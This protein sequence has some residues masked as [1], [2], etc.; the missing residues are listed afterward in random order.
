MLK[1]QII[2]WGWLKGVYIATIIIAGGF[3][4][5]IIFMPTIAMTLLGVSC[6]PA[7][8][9]TLG[10]VFLAFGLLSILGLRDPLKYV[11]ILLLQLVYKTIWLLGVVLP[12]LLQG[13]FPEGEIGTAILFLLIVA[14]DLIAIPFRY[15]FSK[16]TAE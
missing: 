12:L 15:V 1:Q 8:Y 16:S 13:K 11:P 5:L 6:D 2:R 10:S 4:L 9:G 14:A 7:A 3:G